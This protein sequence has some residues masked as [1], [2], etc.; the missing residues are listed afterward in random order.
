VSQE[1]ETAPSQS[2]AEF[3]EAAWPYLG[4]VYRFAWRLSRDAS[5]AEDLTQETFLQAWRS[6]RRFER[7][8]NCRAWLF[9]ILGFVWSHERRR[10]GREPVVYDDAIVEAASPCSEPPI[11]DHLTDADVLAAL[12]CLPRVL[13]E[14]ILLTDVEGFTYREASNLL[15]IPL[16]T[17]MSRL[18]RGRRLLRAELSDHAGINDDAVGRTHDAG[19]ARIL[20]MT[21]G[22]R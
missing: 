7:G 20:T 10:R 11:P 5:V 6:F 1:T 17:V 18:N 4:A 3:Q 9:G 14:T 13:R 16:G 8:T 15:G 21:K 2:A 22:R 12:D 19:R